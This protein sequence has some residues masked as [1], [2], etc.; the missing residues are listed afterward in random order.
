[1]KGQID[2]K[3]R[4]F[5]GL[6]V[7]DFDRYMAQRQLAKARLSRDTLRALKPDV[8]RRMRA[9]TGQQIVT[10]LTGF[11]LAILNAILIEAATGT[12]P[13]VAIGKRSSISGC[14]D[15][16]ER[17]D[18]WGLIRTIVNAGFKRCGNF[19]SA[20][21]TVALVLFPEGHGFC[22]DGEGGGSADDE[23]TASGG[24]LPVDTSGC[25]TLSRY[26]TTMCRGSVTV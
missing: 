1:M 23:G 19:V 25:R 5:A 26:R 4:V 9:G 8:I 6:R 10:S 15:A 3:V 12:S 20:R 2:P 7:L 18:G 11:A 14:L 13:R 16:F 21:V 17:L 22:R 24:R